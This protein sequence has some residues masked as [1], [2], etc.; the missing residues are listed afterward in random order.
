MGDPG[1]GGG[2][3]FY[4]DMTRVEGSRY[5]EV[6]CFGWQN[7]CDGEAPDPNVAWGCDETAISGADGT[8]I[9]TGE[10]NTADIVAGCADVGIAAKLADGYSKNDLDD[11]FLPSKDELNE[12]CKYA[13]TTGQAQGSDTVCRGATPRS[14]FS[15]ETLD[16]FWSSSERDSTNASYQYIGTGIQSRARKSDGGLHV[17]PVRSF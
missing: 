7:N 5:F 2:T 17:R 12:L 10:Q 9:G 6:A 1:P 16:N 3:I 13:L 14:D 15:N 8:A 11:W 4:V